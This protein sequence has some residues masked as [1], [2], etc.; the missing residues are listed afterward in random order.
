M[1]ETAGQYLDRLEDSY[2]ELQVAK[3]RIAQLEAELAKEKETVTFL[4]ASLDIKQ[5]LVVAENRVAQLEAENNRY[6]DALY[7][8]AGTNTKPSHLKIA[9]KEM[10]LVTKQRAK[11][12]LGGE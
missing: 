11:E 3:Q 9:W 8:I 5:R 1:T 10:M 2:D 7:S 12:A 4:D 6:R